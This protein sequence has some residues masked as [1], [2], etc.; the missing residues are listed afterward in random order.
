[1]N[2][3]NFAKNMNMQVAKISVVF[4]VILMS[5][6]YKTFGQQKFTVVANLT[7][8]EDSTKFYLVNL[9][10]AQ[11]VD[12]AYLL[13]KALTFKGH[14]AF[15]APFRLLPETKDNYFNFWIEDR[16]IGLTGNKNNFS[17]LIVKGSPLNRIYFS[18][19]SKH[20]A[21]DNL[22]DSLVRLA[23]KDMSEKEEN[24][25]MKIWR[26]IS[27]INTKVK[28]I[29][30]NSIA[31]FPPS[32]ITMSELYFLRNDLT[33]DSLK[34]LFNRFPPKLRNT[35]Y[36]KVIKEYISTSNLKIGSHFKDIVGRNLNNKEVK[37]SDYKNK[38]ILLDFWASWCGPCRLENKEL[39]I[40]FKKYERNGFEV[41]SF[42]IDTDPEAWKLASEQDS[43]TW[44]NIS[45]L[46]G[47]FS[48]QAASYK[49]R[50][51]PKAILINRNG[52]IEEILDG[53][54]DSKEGLIW[55]ESK[56]QALIK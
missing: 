32:L 30:I 1:M 41:V 34:L 36:G 11:D 12:S 25:A 18:V 47:F 51:I 22:R 26:S 15:P 4:M 40:L 23:N 55:L 24:K 50:A 14:L 7:G 43:I 49:I 3:A 31:T 16:A 52:T 6:C 21:L 10:S 17:N 37:L 53:Y 8:F 46:R 38:V 29:R 19:L 9:D 39:G 56:I 13:H 33:T 20:L 45:D 28:K 35:K 42:S 48:K 5:G 27:I 44:V 54:N 2:S